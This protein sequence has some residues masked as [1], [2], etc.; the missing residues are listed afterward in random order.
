MS[1]GFQDHFSQDSASYRD[2]RPRYPEEMFSYL[3]G[4][5]SGHGAAWD[6]ATG[7][8]QAAVDLGN[9]FERVYASDASTGQ[10]REAQPRANVRYVAAL[11]ERAPFSGKSMDLILVAQ[12]LH[13]LDLEPFYREAHRILKPTGVFAACSYNLLRVDSSVDPLLD[14]LYSDV[15][16]PFW[17]PQRRLVED[18]YRSLAFPF[19]EL[20]TPPFTLEQRW[21]FSRLAGYLGTWSATRRFQATRGQDALADA[22]PRLRRAWGPSE[23]IRTVRWPLV[24]RVGRIAD[25]AGNRL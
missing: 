14:E 17:P 25:H 22:N 24:L 10:L 20:E 8:G 5:T 19:T 18:G 4:L 21:S 11:A 15:L 2:F 1:T 16:G 9:H 7:S 3:A 6:C 12:A 13:W 23:R